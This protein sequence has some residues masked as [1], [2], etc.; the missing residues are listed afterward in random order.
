MRTSPALALDLPAGSDPRPAHHARRTFSDL[1]D[2]VLSGAPRPSPGV[3]PSSLPLLTSRPGNAAPSGRARNCPQVTQLDLELHRRHCI[4]AEW[5]VAP[6]PAR[7]L[8]LDRGEP[9][10]ASSR[11]PRRRAFDTG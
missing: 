7:N 3:F 4:A 1:M 10:P 11:F 6:S 9:Q 8:L 2:T 5:P